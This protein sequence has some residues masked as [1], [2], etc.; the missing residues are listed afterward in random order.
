MISTFEM[1][2]VISL[3]FLFFGILFD[4]FVA[5]VLIRF[6]RSDLNRDVFIRTYSANPGRWLAY[7]ILKEPYSKNNKNNK[8]NH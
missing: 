7:K 1:V 6:S 2:L 3:F 4:F 8:K 5:M